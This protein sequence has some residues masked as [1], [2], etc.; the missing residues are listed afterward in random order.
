MQSELVTYRDVTVLIL[1][2]QATNIYFKK[3]KL[4]LPDAK[5][6]RRTF[7]LWLQSSALL[8]QDK[9]FVEVESHCTSSIKNGI[10]SSDHVFVLS[11]VS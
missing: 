6:V 2:L 8:E 10:S 3:V 9:K 7:S 1:F 11:I 4:A 5:H